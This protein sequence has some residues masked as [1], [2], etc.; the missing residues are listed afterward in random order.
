M[1]LESWVILFV[2]NLAF[3]QLNDSPVR[4]DPKEIDPPV[5]QFQASFTN[6]RVVYL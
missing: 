4:T 2:K 3:G 1:A 6:D 5:V